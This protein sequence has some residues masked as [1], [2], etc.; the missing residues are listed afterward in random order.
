MGQTEARAATKQ[1]D[2]KPIAAFNRNIREA[3]KGAFDRE[4]APNSTPKFAPIGGFPGLALEAKI[5]PCHRT[6]AYRLAGN[7]GSVRRVV[8]RP[9]WRDRVGFTAVGWPIM[10]ELAGLLCYNWRG[11]TKMGFRYRKSLRLA[12]GMR[13]NLTGRGVSSFSV[14]RPGSTLNFGRK[15]VRGTVGIP[16]SGLSYSSRLSSGSGVLPALIAVVSVG[17]LISA[18]RGNR[19]AQVALV[20]TVVL[21][22][23]LLFM[24]HHVSE[25]IDSISIRGIE[26]DTQTIREIR[27]SIPSESDGPAL[28]NSE[29]RELQRSKTHA[30]G[31]V[32]IEPSNSPPEESKSLTSKD[33]QT[34]IVERI[35]PELVAPGLQG[36]G[37]SNGELSPA[38]LLNLSNPAEALRAQLRLMSLGYPVGR[39]D[40]VWGLQSQFALNEFR[41][42]HRLGTSVQWDEGTQAA[43]FS[44]VNHES[45]SD[46]EAG[47]REIPTKAPSSPAQNPMRQ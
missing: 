35:P 36:G 26:G 17:T 18:A 25:P 40:G 15:G 46:L 8:G 33:T 41:R 12:R 37:A 1:L 19:L 14:G 11:A 38:G 21:G 20:V 4:G 10:L 24:T 2:A 30:T 28:E 29:S 23:A 9:C 32:G 39:P 13:L 22:G 6:P 3:A 34:T 44:G 47:Q 45:G 43:L 16:G 7:R 42:K 5:R 27:P 31:G